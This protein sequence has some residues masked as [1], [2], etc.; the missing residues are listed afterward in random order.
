MK[1]CTSAHSCLHAGHLNDAES[2]KRNISVV[3][4]QAHSKP[5]G[6]G[7]SACRF[8]TMASGD[9]S[10]RS[11]WGESGALFWINTSSNE[12]LSPGFSFSLT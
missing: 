5:G 6:G 12:D 11:L 7:S 4:S 1:F 3:V 10:A 8:V 9:D 2:T